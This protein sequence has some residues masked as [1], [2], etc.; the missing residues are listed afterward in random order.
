MDNIGFRLKMIQPKT[1]II[2]HAKSREHLAIVRFSLD[3]SMSTMCSIVEKEINVIK[4]W[5]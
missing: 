3:L 5:R 2:K 1:K 4:K